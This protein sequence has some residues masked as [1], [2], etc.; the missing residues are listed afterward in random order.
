MSS[1]P[2]KPWPELRSLRDA[3]LA[4]DADARAAGEEVITRALLIG[5]LNARL[6]G[7]R[8]VSAV[9]ASR[10]TGLSESDFHHLAQ[11]AHGMD[12][13]RRVG[14][15]TYWRASQVYRVLDADGV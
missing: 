2:L 6:P 15:T 4:R 11:T 12:P 9:D 3:L 10:L 5:A 1:D 7:D 13:A 14:A 8:L